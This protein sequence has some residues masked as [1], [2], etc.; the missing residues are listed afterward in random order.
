M[1]F[2]LK[3]VVV[4]DELCLPPPPWFTV[5]IVSLAGR[6]SSQISDFVFKTWYFYA[7]SEGHFRRTIHRAIAPTVDPRP[8]GSIWREMGHRS[9]RFHFQ[10]HGISMWTNKVVR[11]YT[12]RP[13]VNG[14][15]TVASA[16]FA[17]MGASGIFD[18]RIWYMPF[19]A[20]SSFSRNFLDEPRN[21]FQNHGYLLYI[22]IY[23]FFLL[24][25]PPHL[26][27]VAEPSA[28]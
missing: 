13:S 28:V 3:S 26:E 8:N 20:E 14:G 12:S 10:S 16:N 17:V 22:Y 24:S 19:F 9:S 21:G 5:V 6:A 18:F 2:Y 4:K 11:D 23:H 7:T 25:P 15:S 27:L 1:A